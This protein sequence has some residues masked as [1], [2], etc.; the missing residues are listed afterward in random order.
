MFT[1]MAPLFILARSSA[2]SVL[3]ER[4][5]KP[6]KTPRTSA[7]DTSASL[8]TLVTPSS[9]HRSSVRFWLQAT[10]SMPNAFAT[11]TIAPPRWPAPTRPRVL[12]ASGM[13]NEVCQ[14]P[15]RMPR[16]SM[17]VRFATAKM[18]AHAISD[19]VGRPRGPPQQAPP[20]DPGLVVDNIARP[21]VTNDQLEVGKAFEHRPGKACPL[22]G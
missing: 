7:D 21:A 1:R 13:G 17:P 5:E 6:R 22:L 10:T 3:R 9:A 16:S 12:P 4:A 11:G 20:L 14:P 8:V 15:A 19:G 18:S 2:R